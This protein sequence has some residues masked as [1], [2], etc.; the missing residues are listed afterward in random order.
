MSSTTSKPLL[1]AL[2]DCE[3][4]YASCE[5]LFRP[6]LAGKPVVVLSNNDGCLVSMMPEAKALGFRGGEPYF[7]VA[8][9]LKKA[10]AA[11]FSSNYTLYADLSRRVIATMNSLAPESFELPIK[12]VLGLETEPAMIN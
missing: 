9:Q 1:W 7:K 12:G 6:D 4:F 10:G 11:V 8:T 2:V 3:S 5:R